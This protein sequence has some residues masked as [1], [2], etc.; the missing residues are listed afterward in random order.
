MLSILENINDKITKKNKE[1]RILWGIDKYTLVH[2][3]K[4]WIKLKTEIDNIE[5]SNSHKMNNDF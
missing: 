2:L 4:K 3:Y 1:I 5:A